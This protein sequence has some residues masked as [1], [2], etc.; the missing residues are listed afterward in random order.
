M[1]EPTKQTKPKV[2]ME[3]VEKWAKELCGLRYWGAMSSLLVML[4]EAGVE[5][6][7]KVKEE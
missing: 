3:F 7:G 5:V 4:R 6:E 1:S 2:S